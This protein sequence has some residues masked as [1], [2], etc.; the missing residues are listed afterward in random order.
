M[1]E[2][3]LEGEVLL[4]Q[5]RMPT[6]VRGASMEILCFDEQ[7]PGNL[8]EY[9]AGPSHGVVEWSSRNEAEQIEIGGVPAER[10]AYR[11][12]RNGKSMWKD[13]VCFRRG[14]RVYSFIGLSWESD[15][16]AREQFHRAVE[17]TIWQ[18]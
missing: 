12:D 7:S 1:P 11:A 17:S 8:F 18:D 3:E 6:A 14:K 13:V 9:H 5:Y 2:D 15:E 16:K 4:V 10:L